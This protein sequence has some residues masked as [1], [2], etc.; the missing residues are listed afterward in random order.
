VDDWDSDEFWDW[1][2]DE[3]EDALGAELDLEDLADKVAALFFL[4]DPDFRPDDEDGYHLGTLEAEEWWPLL[5]QL[6]EADVYLGHV[7]ALALDLRPL[8]GLDGVPTQ[9]LE[10][11]LGFLQ[12]ALEGDL[13]LVGTERRQVSTRRLVKIAAVVVDL[14]LELSE[15]HRAAIEAWANVHRHRLHPHAFGQDAGLDFLGAEGELPPAVLGF[16]MMVGLSLMLWPERGGGRPV[17]D[18]LPDPGLYTS[19]LNAWE[20][21]PDNPSVTEEGSGVAEV[22]FAQGRLAHTLAQ[23]G[24]S[25]EEADGAE[26]ARAYSR[27]SRS[28]LWLHNQCR[29]CPQR[30]GLTCQVSR[31][32]GSKQ[33]VALLDVASASAN[34][35]QVDGC[36]YLPV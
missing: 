2:D 29:H 34:A 8:L 1:F 14:A 32:V 11:P 26:M 18:R 3:D 22:L 19:L 20:S 12:Q 23:L 9:V 7:W 27:L 4:N 17:G 5:S 21:L 13:P 30:A 6:Y 33:P 31:V 36:I 28:I 10:D 16:S 15:A 25:G 24:T 35:G